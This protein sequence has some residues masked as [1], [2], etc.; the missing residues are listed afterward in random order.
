[1]SSVYQFIIVLTKDNCDFEEKYFGY[2]DK[3]PYLKY[4][5]KRIKII[6]KAL[7]FKY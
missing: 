4:L 2:K 7:S 5:I 1:L 6:I 3:Y